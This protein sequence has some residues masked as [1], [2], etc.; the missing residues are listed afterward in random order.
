MFFIAVPRIFLS[1]YIGAGHLIMMG[2]AKFMILKVVQPLV[3]LIMI[4]KIK[5]KKKTEKKR[6]DIIELYLDI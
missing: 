6:E 2:K 3:L 4:K 1:S 5:K